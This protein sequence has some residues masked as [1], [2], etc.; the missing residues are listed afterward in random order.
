M[1][2]EHKRQPIAIAGTRLSDC[3]HDNPNTVQDMDD[4]YNMHD[5]NRHPCRCNRT[6][7]DANC[8][9]SKPDTEEALQ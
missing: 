7:Q 4:T 2:R 6:D 3:H 5:D 1:K 8:D 9:P